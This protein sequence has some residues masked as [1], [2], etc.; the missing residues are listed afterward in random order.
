MVGRTSSRIP[1]TARVPP[2]T[3]NLPSLEVVVAFN[4]SVRHNDEWFEEP[5]ELE[6]VERVL[7]D[8]Q[9]SIDPLVAAAIATMF[10]KWCRFGPAVSDWYV[11]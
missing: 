5:D 10:V 2:L 8:L 7:D 11:G 3:L 1:G 9:T 4:A 6:R